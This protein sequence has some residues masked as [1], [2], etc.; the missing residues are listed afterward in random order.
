MKRCILYLMF[1]ATAVSAASRV[2]IRDK[3]FYVDGEPFYI[4]GIGYSPWRPHQH[5]GISYVDTNRRWTA[6]DF[7]RIKEAHFNVVRTWDALSPEELALAKKYGLMVLQGIWL[8]PHQNFA[9]QHN[10]DS[11]LAQVQNVAEQSRDS[12]NVLGYVIMTEPWPEAVVESGEQETLEFFRRLKRAI[13]AIDPRP[14]SMDSWPPLAFLDHH[15]FDFVTINHFS[16]WP[17]SLNHALGFAGVVRWFADHLAQDRPLI[18]GETGGYA[19]SQSTNGAHGGAGGYSEYDQSIKDLESLRGAVQGHAG[20]SVLVSW[21]DTWHYPTDPDTHDNEPWEWDGVLAIPTDSRKD[22][23][24][25][26]RRVYQDVSSFNEALLLEPK[27]DHYYGLASPIAVEACGADNVA[28]MR[29]SVNGGDWKPLEGSGHGGWRGFFSLPK[30]ARHRQRV[31]I[32]ALDSGGS[33]LSTQS[34]SFIAAG[35]PEQIV[36]SS[37]PGGRSKEALTFTATVTDARHEPIAQRK[38]HFGFF[39]P[40]SLRETQGILLTDDQGRAT[41]TCSL[42]PEPK[43]QYLFVAAGTDSPDR[44]RAGDM[45]IFRL[46][47]ER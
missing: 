26:P 29:L 44:V 1:F 33:Q 42:P 20:G 10:Q 18:I 36:L 3:R 2:E 6:M 4:R 47:H 27:A 22:M 28:E 24:G 38:V 21:I 5:P 39:Y 9:D 45:R 32:Q 19:V 25:I 30:L 14:V 7:K 17:K 12:D 16:F 34:V 31:A 37:Q 41:L 8:D 11:C 43:D 40:I 23:D 13:Q 35:G 15:A 46:G